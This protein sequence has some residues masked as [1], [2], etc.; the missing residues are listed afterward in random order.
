MLIFKFLFG[1]FLKA[2][3]YCSCSSGFM[4]GN[5]VSL[6]ADGNTVYTIS[7]SGWTDNYAGALKV[8]LLKFTVLN[9]V[10]Q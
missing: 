4:H 6:S 2:S 9:S 8:A 1:H 5:S 7:N 3:L 10:N